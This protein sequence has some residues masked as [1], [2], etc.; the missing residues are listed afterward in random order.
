MNTWL[1]VNESNEHFVVNIGDCL[2]DWISNGF[3]ITF[4]FLYIF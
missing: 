2:M 4:P 3:F 1:K